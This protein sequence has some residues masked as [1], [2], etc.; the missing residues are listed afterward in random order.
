VTISRKDQELSWQVVMF[1]GKSLTNQGS[2][3]IH[4]QRDL[5]VL[6]LRPHVKIGATTTGSGECKDDFQL[7]MVDM[8]KDQQPA[9][10]P[11]HVGW[12]S[13][14][15]A[16]SSTTCTCWVFFGSVQQGSKRSTKPVDQAQ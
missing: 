3:W 11:S 12:R 4:L 13:T 8:I 10:N 15:I 9:M 6:L 1:T 7:S 14:L 16:C 5:D 2:Q